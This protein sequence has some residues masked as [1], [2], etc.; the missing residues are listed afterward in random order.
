MD[1][2]PWR[3][4]RAKR[5]VY[6]AGHDRPIEPFAPGGDLLSV[7]EF[8]G[9]ETPDSFI[10]SAAAR[11]ANRPAMAGAINGSLIDN[12]DSGDTSPVTEG[13][14]TASAAVEWLTWNRR[15]VSSWPRGH[16]AYL[17]N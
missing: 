9:S 17:M 13:S 7:V 6:T 3:R 4:L 2:C 16:P 14:F 8:S 1:S 10:P 5:H 12:P 15:F 11:L